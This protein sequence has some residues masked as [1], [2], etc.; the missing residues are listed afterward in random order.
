MRVWS[1]AGVIAAVSVGALVLGSTGFSEDSAKKQGFERERVAKSVKPTSS[2]PPGAAVQSKRAR[3][4]TKYF[5][6]NSPTTVPADGASS[7]T[8]LTCPKRHKAISGFYRTDG[9]IAVDWFSVGT[10]SPRKWE[11]GFFDLSGVEG[12]AFEGVVCQKR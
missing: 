8:V 6:A 1:V 3:R 2:V 5:I 12:Q 9:F 11:Y 4:G 7:V 10:S